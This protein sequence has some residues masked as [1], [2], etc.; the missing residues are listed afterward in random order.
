MEN[1]NRIKSTPK[2][3]P[4]FLLVHNFSVSVK[5]YRKF[6]MFASFFVPQSHTDLRIATQ[7]QINEC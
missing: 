6:V 3:W 1:V 5:S 2:N 7:R 4:F